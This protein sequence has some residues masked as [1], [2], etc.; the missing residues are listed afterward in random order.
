MSAVRDMKGKDQLTPLDINMIRIIT[1][2]MIIIIVVITIM[3]ISRII[4]ILKVQICPR[5]RPC[6]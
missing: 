2:I 1:I 5:L 4:I 3:F 6:H